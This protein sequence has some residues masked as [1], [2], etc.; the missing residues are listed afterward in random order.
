MPL[1]RR[2]AALAAT[3]AVAAPVLAQSVARDLNAWGM[4][5]DEW[6][7]LGA[8]GESLYAVPE[9]IEG[10]A[11]SWSAPSGASG[12]VVVEAVGPRADGSPCVTLRHEVRLPRLEGTETFRETRCR[13]DG[14]WVISAQ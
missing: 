3:L 10:A 8:A 1:A 11:A 4:G 5:G 13:I 12:D 2:L 6:A 9:P 7:R 14:K